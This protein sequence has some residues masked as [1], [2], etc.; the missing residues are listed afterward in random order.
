M[1]DVE[2]KILDLELEAMNGDIP[3]WY[4]YEEIERLKGYL[5][6]ETRYSELKR[7][8]QETSYTHVDERSYI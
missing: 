6:D 1:Y 5:E 4:A 7:E 2:Q 3:T 8:A